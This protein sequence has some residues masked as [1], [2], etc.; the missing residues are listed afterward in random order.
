MAKERFNIS[1]IETYLY[2]LL[3][4]QVSE[5]TFAG[6]LP[7]TIQNEWNDMVLIDCGSSVR[8][9]RAIADGVVLIWLYARPQGDGSKNVPLLST[10]ETAL[11]GLIDNAHDEFYHIERNAM[12]SEYDS[13]R[14][15]HCNIIELILKIN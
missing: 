11:N 5:N 10:M 15:W 4:G 7:D 14:K 12:Y 6:T 3:N 8:D 2:G 9:R 1:K 13:N